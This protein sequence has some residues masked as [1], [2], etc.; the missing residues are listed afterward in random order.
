MKLLEQKKDKAHKLF[1][2][3]KK[4]VVVLFLLVLYLVIAGYFN[5]YIPCPIKAITGFYCPGCGITRMI[6]SLFE[7]DFYAAFRYNPL[8]FISLPFD[9]FL[10]FDYV[11]RKNK[12]LYKK[13]PELVWYIIIILLIVYGILRNIPYFSFLAPTN[14]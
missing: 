6:K 3:M 8:L 9:L 14:V 5:I 12:S 13:I 7:L 2:F 4:F 1:S 11:F 10:Y